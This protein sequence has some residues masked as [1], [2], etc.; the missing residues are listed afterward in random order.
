MWE[1]YHRARGCRVPRVPHIGGALQ[2][3][4]FGPWCC[5][6]SVPCVPQVRRFLRVPRSG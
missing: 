3:K 6:W 1:L 5:E 2:V 4:V